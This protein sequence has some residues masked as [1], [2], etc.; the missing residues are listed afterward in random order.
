M[1]IY[2]SHKYGGKL[3]NIERAKK[4]TH[5]LQMAHPENCYVCPLLNFSYLQYKELG[6]N[7]ELDLCI[8]LLSVC[9][10]LLVASNISKGVQAEIDFA[11]LVHMEVEYLYGVEQN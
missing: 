11:N 9:D 4:I 10:K 2:V 7:E 6:Y 3:E 8:D 1:M 5:D